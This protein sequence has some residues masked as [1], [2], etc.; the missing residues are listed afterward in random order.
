[1]QKP[2]MAASSLALM[3]AVQASRSKAWLACPNSVW[4]YAWNRPSSAHSWSR[5]AHGGWATEMRLMWRGS[6]QTEASNGQGL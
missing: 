6:M 3:S 4:R 5:P 1:M 2:A